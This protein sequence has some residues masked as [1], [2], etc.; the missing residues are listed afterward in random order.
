MAYFE[1]NDLYDAAAYEQANPFLLLR[2]GRYILGRGTETWQASRSGSAQAA[3]VATYRYPITITLNHKD[4]EMV[5]FSYYISWL[6]LSGEEIAASQNY[7]LAQETILQVQELSEAAG[8]HFLLVYLPSKSHVYLPYVNDTE[9]IE[10]V[11][12]DVPR[13]ALDDEEFIQFTN[14]HATLELIHQH[15]DDQARLLADF[16]AEQNISFLDL[17]PPFQKE[18]GAGAELYYPFDTHW[19]QLGHN[20]AGKLIDEYIRLHLGNADPANK[21]LGN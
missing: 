19:N 13:L 21:T 6:S 12:M 3:K 14:E 4:L 1:G 16:A 10:R 15:M 18:A 7:Q 2:F 5:F 20:L 11:F 8:A 9:T 17:T